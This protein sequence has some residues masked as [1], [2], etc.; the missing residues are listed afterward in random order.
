[1]QVIGQDDGCS[2]Q[3]D[4]P[5][6]LADHF[7]SSILEYQQTHFYKF[8]GAGITEQ[9]VNMSPE[10]PSRLWS[11]LDIVPMVFWHGL[12]ILGDPPDT[13]TIDEDADSMVRKCLMLFGPTRQPRIQVGY[14]SQV[15][16]DCGGHARITRLEQYPATVGHRTWEATMKYAKSLKRDRVKIAFFNSTPQGGG[17]A[18]MRHAL[19]RFLRLV[20]V[21]ARWYVPRPKPEIFRIT[22]TNHNILQGVADPKE[23]LTPNQQVTAQHPK[24]GEEAAFGGWIR[25]VWGRA[26]ERT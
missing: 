19:I 8:A 6:L 12:K 26:S 25:G 2:A 18:L 11:E 15:E 17:V 9:L 13:R 16:V 10:L 4:M 23:R 21:D 20:G 7:I 22:K 3:K 5:S 14:K 24:Q 1:M